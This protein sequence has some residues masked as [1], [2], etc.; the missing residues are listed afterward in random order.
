[1]DLATTI[2]QRAPFVFITTHRVKPGHLDDVK[3]LIQRYTAFLE[4]HDDGLRSH[5]AYLDEEH[6]I[7]DLVQ[8]QTDAASAD[9]HM[10]LIAPWVGPASE[11]TDT[12]AVTIFG[13]PG[14]VL[15]TTL[16]SIWA[17]GATVTVHQPDGA[18]F[19]RR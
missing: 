18:G 13:E 16:E 12:L 9:R 2:D 14:P 17:T 4:E 10:E 11:H 1:M 7:V 15:Q 6:Q 8:V 19:I 5:G 3:D